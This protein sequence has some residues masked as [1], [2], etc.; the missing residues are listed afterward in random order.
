MIEFLKQY[1]V[2]REQNS[3]TKE[4]THLYFYS[5]GHQNKFLH[6]GKWNIPDDQLEQFFSLYIKEYHEGHTFVEAHKKDISPIVIDIDIKQDEEERKLTT[7]LANKIIEIL[8]N[9]IAK[10]TDERPKY[11]VMQRPDVYLCRDKYKDGFHIIYPNIVVKYDYRIKLYKNTVANIGELMKEYNIDGNINDIYDESVIKRNGMMLYKCSKYMNNMFIPPYEIIIKNGIEIQDPDELDMMEVLNDLSLRNKH[12]ETKCNEGYIVLIRPLVDDTMMANNIS[13]SS[14]QHTNHPI[15]QYSNNDV[16]KFR[17]LVMKLP[18]NYYNNEQLWYK[19]GAIC[20]N[21][22]IDMNCEDELKNVFIEFSKQSTKYDD[23]NNEFLIDRM[24]D[25]YKNNTGNGLKIGSLI[26]YLRDEN[27]NIDREEYIGTMDIF[28]RTAQN[29]QND[30]EIEVITKHIHKNYKKYKIKKDV[31]LDI[32]KVNSGLVIAKVIDDKYCFYTNSNHDNYHIRIL[33]NNP[34]SSSIINGLGYTEC[35]FCNKRQPIEGISL[36]AEFNNCVFIQNNY[37]GG[38]GGNSSSKIL[39]FKKK[40]EIPLDHVLN[41]ISYEDKSDDELTIIGN[42]MKK[43]M[44]EFDEFQSK[45]NR[46][47]ALELWN[48]KGNASKEELLRMAQNDDILKLYGKKYFS[49]LMLKEIT[50]TKIYKNT[51]DIYYEI[52]NI[53]KNNVFMI[54]DIKMNLIIMKEQH[55]KYKNI[56]RHVMV[57]L[58][59]FKKEHEDIVMYYETINKKGELVYENIKFVDIISHIQEI[60]YDRM[61]M[62]PYHIF[63]EQKITGIYKTLNVFSPMIGNLLNDYDVSLI[64]PILRHIKEVWCNYDDFLYKYVLSYLAQIIQTPWKKTDIAIVLCGEQGCGKTSLIED[65]IKHIMGPNCGL[66]TDGLKDLVN[67]QFQSFLENKLLI[68]C[69]EP[70]ALND[71]IFST[72]VE[73][74]KNFITC[75]T[76]GIEKKF[77]EKYTIDVYHNLIIACNHLDGIHIQNEKERRFLVLKCNE[78]YIRNFEYFG[79]LRKCSDNKKNM[80]IFFSFLYNYEDKVSLQPIPLTEGKQEA[81]IDKMTTINKFLF[82]PEIRYDIEKDKRYNM[83]QLYDEYKIWYDDNGF[84]KNEIQSKDKFSKELK[85]WIIHKGKETDSVSNIRK[86]IFIFNDEYFKKINI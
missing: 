2:I 46:E 21:V 79:S 61:I 71:L 86:N 7:E 24:W 11:Y 57:P 13:T 26:K 42:I 73:S 22:S 3:S 47:N 69:D 15:G 32:E 18:E 10:F 50:D 56:Y 75:N 9:E 41:C 74:L 60:Q 34:L 67:K 12:I 65:M 37:Y 19:I 51:E 39:Q 81:I 16:T 82:H 38:D 70:T 27:I 5:R 85:I 29:Q 78:K 44:Y 20:H 64:E 62:E 84:T 30:N 52:Y 53:C 66:Q 17:N 54:N 80:D 58:K 76:I 68:L 77:Q 63:E 36:S 48:N 55:D 45:I 23:A 83:T 40:K 31:K 25:G 43:N 72:Y 59:I 28:N 6:P 8:N 4:Y 35:T 14:V 33:M 1:E 49:L